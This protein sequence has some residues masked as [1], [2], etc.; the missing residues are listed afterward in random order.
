[1][2]LSEKGQQQDFIWAFVF[3]W[4]YEH[5]ISETDKKLQNLMKAKN[6]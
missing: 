6:T 5:F 1:M 2:A 3:I 4:S